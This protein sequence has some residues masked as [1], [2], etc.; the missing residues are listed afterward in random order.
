MEMDYGQQGEGGEA[1][2]AD[3][4]TGQFDVYFH[5]QRKERQIRCHNNKQMVLKITEV[6]TN[7]NDTGELVT[8]LETLS[9]PDPHTS[10]LLS[11]GQTEVII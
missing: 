1:C 6:T 9:S 7:I 4:R 3:C 10:A 8:M 5:F 11:R 2:P